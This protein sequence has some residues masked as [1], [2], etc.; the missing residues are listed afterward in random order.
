MSDRRFFIRLYQS[1]RLH[2]LIVKT[3]GDNLLTLSCLC[4]CRLYNGNT[5]GQ[6]FG[7][8]CC[9]GD[10]IGCGLSF[11]S[12]VGQLTVFFTKNGK[13]VSA[14]W[15][16]DISLLACFLIPEHFTV[17]SQVNVLYQPQHLNNYL[18]DETNWYEVKVHPP[19]QIYYLWNGSY[20]IL[21]CLH[22]TYI[23]F[24]LFPWHF[25]LELQF[26]L[27]IQ[28]CGASSTNLFTI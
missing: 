7:P 25:E 5:V 11:D 8:K 2:N 1:L 4:A 14:F 10:R 12:D 3:A 21:T 26:F 20:E 24:T 17:G 19:H 22:Y 9:R 16:D 18:C 6:Q 28:P 23:R 15:S 27:S 13:E